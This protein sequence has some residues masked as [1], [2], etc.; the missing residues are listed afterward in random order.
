VKHA[1]YAAELVQPIIGRRAEQ[2]IAKAK[3]LQDILGEHQDA[4]VAEE[5]LRKVSVGTPAAQPL[6]RQLI[7]RQRKRRKTALAA[8][9]NKWPRLKRRGRKVYGD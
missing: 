6:A 4:V 9:G 5:S 1:R 7:E 8:F 3:K 2:L